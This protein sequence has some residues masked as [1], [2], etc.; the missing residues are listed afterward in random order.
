MAVNLHA[1]GVVRRTAPGVCGPSHETDL[2]AASWRWRPTAPLPWISLVLCSAL[3]AAC[4]TAPP[5][6]APAIEGSGSYAPVPGADTRRYVLEVGQSFSGATL[7]RFADPVYPPALLPLKLPPV[8]LV[9]RLII[10]ADGRVVR[11]Q[12]DPPAQV[13]QIGHATA[14]M[15]AIAACTRQWRF[16]PLIIITSHMRNGRNASHNEARPFSL[17]Y[18]FRFELRGGKPRATL[19]RH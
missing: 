18:V 8:T 14:F 1:V 4:A 7:A 15:D 2:H 11:V 16:A 19:A 10:D 17:V 12:S 9:V 3:L 13:Q 5:A 6:P